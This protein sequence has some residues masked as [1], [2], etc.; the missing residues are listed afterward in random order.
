[1]I[2]LGIDPGYATV[3]Y[4][5]PIWCDHNTPKNRFFSTAGNDL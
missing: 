3:G 1:M 4:G 5:G 2:I